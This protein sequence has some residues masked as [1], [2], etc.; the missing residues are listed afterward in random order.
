MS[1]QWY[2]P[3][4][5]PMRENTIRYELHD[6]P[7]CS[8]C[9]NEVDLE[10]TEDSR[11]R[12][13][14]YNGC[15]IN[16]CAMDLISDCPMQDANKASI[17]RANNGI[18]PLEQTIKTPKILW[19]A[20]RQHKHN[21]GGDELIPA[22]DYTETCAIVTTLQARIAM[23]EN[24]AEAGVDITEDDSRPRTESRGVRWKRFVEALRAAGYLK[25]EGK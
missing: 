18:F 8:Y 15:Y 9:G 23:L 22:F 14:L 13:H 10:S 6:V 1:E 25:G 4:C 17:L 2:C 24:V 12:A 16:H 11:N 5:G 7:L 19:P 21:T 3:S 20:L